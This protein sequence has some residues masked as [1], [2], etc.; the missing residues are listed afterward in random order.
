MLKKRWLNFILHLGSLISLQKQKLVPATPLATIP[1]AA[2]V[3]ILEAFLLIISLPVYIFISPVEL[4]GNDKQAIVTYRLRRIVSL[5]VVLGTLAI[6]LGYFLVSVVGASLFPNRT[7]AAASTWDFN[8]PLSY[9]YDSSKIQVVDGVAI[10]RAE[11]P[12]SSETVPFIEGSASGETSVT[13]ATGDTTN[14]NT[15]ATVESGSTVVPEAAGGTSADTSVTAPTT[16]PTVAPTPVPEPTPEPAPAVAP[17]PTPAPTPAP[18][19]G[20]LLNYLKNT[21][22]ITSVRAQALTCEATLQ[23]LVPLIVTPLKAWTGFTEVANKNGGE[24]YYELSVDGGVTWLYWNSQF[25]W[26]NSGLTQFNTASEVN[27]HITALSATTGTILFRT[28]FVSDCSHDMQ[29]LSLTVDYERPETAFTLAS[30]NPAITFTDA[31]GSALTSAT[32]TVYINYLGEPAASVTLAGDLNLANQV[33]GTAVGSSWLSLAEPVISSVGDVQLILPK[34]NSDASVRVCP[35]ALAAVSIIPG[36][37]NETILHSGQS[38]ASGYTLVR[39]DDP[40]HW[41]IAVSTTGTLALG[42]MEVAPETTPVSALPST[43]GTI[44]STNN[45]STLSS[46]ALPANDYV[47]TGEVTFSSSGEA[48]VII[49]H[50]NDNNL[51]KLVFKDG[52]VQ[53]AGLVNGLPTVATNANLADFV[54]HVGENYKFKIQVNGSQLRAKWWLSSEAETPTWL[55]YA[56]DDRI[57]SGGVGIDT[58]TLT[59]AAFR[60]LSVS[61]CL[62]DETVVAP[63]PTTSSEP[64]VSAPV[65]TLTPTSAVVT[66]T[67]PTLA[68]S[69]NSSPEVSIVAVIEPAVP[70]ESVNAGTT[71]ATPV[72][73]S[74]ATV[75]ITPV[76]NTIET[77]LSTGTVVISEPATVTITQDPVRHELEVVIVGTNDTTTTLTA[78]AP[79]DPTEEHVVTVIITD[80][81]TT[82]YVDGSVVDTDR[83][84]TLPAGDTTEVATDTPLIDIVQTVPEILS[85]VQI[86]GDYVQITNSP[87][88]LT[89]TTAEQKTDDGYVD[90]RYVLKDAESNYVSLAKYEYSLTGNFTGEEKM[91]TPAVIDNDHGGLATLKT[92]PNGIANTFIWDAKADIGNVYAPHVYVRLKP[93]DGIEAGSAV[94]SEPLAVDLKGPIVSELEV[95]EL[96]DPMQNSIFIQYKALD[97]TGYAM[98]N[99]TFSLDNGVNWNIKPNFFL[100]GTNEDAPTSDKYIHIAANGVLKRIITGVPGS[101]SGIE[102]D[103]ARVALDVEDSFGNKNRIIS[104]PFRVDERAPF[105]LA[106]FHGAAANTT[107]IQWNWSPVASESNFDSYEIWY[108]QDLAAVEA[109]RTTGAKRWSTEQ[110][111]DLGI[112]GTHSTIITGL[113]SETTYYAEITA[114]DTFG[115]QTT[116][117]AA[118]YVTLGEIPAVITASTTVIVTASSSLPIAI[119]GVDEQII[120]VNPSPTVETNV[121][122]GGS[123]SGGGGGTFHASGSV[124]QTVTIPVLPLNALSAPEKP[125]GGFDITINADTRQTDSS[126][127]TLILTAGA[128]TTAMA[129]SNFADLHDAVQEPFSP[130]KAWNLCSEQ[131]GLKQQAQCLPGEHTVYVRFYTSY[132]ESTKTI[133]DTIILNLPVNAASGGGINGSVS[134]SGAA[135]GSS[136]SAPAEGVVNNSGAAGVVANTPGV[137]SQSERVN[138][139]TIQAVVNPASQALINELTVTKESPI[140]ALPTVTNVRQGTLQNGIELSGTSIPH[141]KVAIFLHSDQVV[142]YTTEAD[143]QG[144]WKFTHDQNSTKLAPGEHTIYAVTYDPA[145]GIKSKPTPL[146]TFI[147][148]ENKLATVL[149]Y[150][151]LWTTL[152]TLAMAL[153]VVVLLVVRKTKGQNQLV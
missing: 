87:P 98:V 26:T 93:T 123:S 78:S 64:T 139:V 126:A 20:G 1:I 105:G 96:F 58:A 46:A 31:T 24:M 128:D 36:C 10:F 88:Q 28:K 120:G 43:C 16:E 71:T 40:S 56:A 59:G 66:E 90:V 41:H 117:P 111:S 131:G 140:L 148:K 53:F 151:H 61:T 143:E 50:A 112:M 54:P 91:M 150:F 52:T 17:A 51:W 79:L 99:T 133:S 138:T 19:T 11:Q 9:L 153:A 7:H 72:V 129:I 22:S 115:N 49:R 57:L 104:N 86:A 6:W 85:Q 147:V 55:L 74:S 106:N 21:F 108:G 89:I 2:S 114:Y 124:P 92:S 97:N 70:S 38:N 145:S 130:T 69:T 142:V 45:L 48:S 125:R 42:A 39:L 141:A 34:T 14:L 116:L 63:E 47:L 137:V 75:T 122:A 101:F 152:L 27:D 100:F 73:S 103:L 76:E 68:E 134:D 95:Q 4:A 119:V 13:P 146:K 132:G 118:A 135:V 84:V 83:G 149:S 136:A 144:L 107:E 94:V 5:S 44:L 33:V 121:G 65:E 62:E 37:L 18:S 80:D 81:Q 102:T 12:A 67:T 109:H 3:L 110:D 60:A 77:T 32:G 82:L 30:G 127:V 15:D 29:L 8:Q 23:S 35:G 25:G 113:K